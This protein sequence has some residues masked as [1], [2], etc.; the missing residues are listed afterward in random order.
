M[1]TSNELV[2]ESR[3]L[4]GYQVYVADS[5]LVEGRTY[6]QTYCLDKDG[7]IPQLDAVVFIG[8]DRAKGNAGHATTRRSD[9]RREQAT[10]S[11]SPARQSPGLRRGRSPDGTRRRPAGHLDVREPRQ[12]HRSSELPLQSFSLLSALWGSTRWALN[13]WGPAYRSPLT[14]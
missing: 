12:L 9:G 2:F 4:N 6:F 7:Q 8:P 5:E 14:T 3:Q 10:G 13:A 11:S 1:L